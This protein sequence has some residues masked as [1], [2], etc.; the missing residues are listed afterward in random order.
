[1]VTQS[2]R[3]SSSLRRYPRGPKGPGFPFGKSLL[4][5]IIAVAL[6]KITG[7]TPAMLMTLLQ[8][9]LG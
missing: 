8:T 4:L 2:S 1:M 3:A 7:L 6:S 5:V 9:F